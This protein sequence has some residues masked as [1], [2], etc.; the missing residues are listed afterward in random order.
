MTGRAL[1]RRCVVALFVLANLSGCA[2]ESSQNGAVASSTTLASMAPSSQ[3]LPPRPAVLSLNGVN[4]CALL[5]TK[6]IGQLKVTRG[7][8]GM[9]NDGLGSPDCLWSSSTEPPHNDWL[10]RL[11]L[12][13]GADRYLDATGAAVVE[14]DGFPAIQTSADGQ[15]PKSHCILYVDVAPGQ[16]L[17]VLYTNLTGDYPGMNHQL[18]C[19]LADEGAEPMVKNLRTLTH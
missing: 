12:H 14:V 19:H 16:S 7:L 2:V 18:A 17:Y 6:Q 15:D 5:T 4:P 1:I 11:I 9:N 3:A 13:Q 8:P 10:A